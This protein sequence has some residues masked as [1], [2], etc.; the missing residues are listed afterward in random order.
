M[1]LSKQPLSRTEIYNSVETSVNSDGEHSKSLADEEGDYAEASE[2][3]SRSLEIRNG[4]KKAILMDVE[5]IEMV[6]LA[7]VV[8]MLYVLLLL[9]LSSSFSNYKLY[10]F[11]LLNSGDTVLYG[12]CSNVL[13][14]YNMFCLCH[15]AQVVGWLLV[16]SF[17]KNT[18]ATNLAKKS[19]DDRKSVSGSFML[20]S[21][22][23]VL[24][25]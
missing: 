14:A 24:H 18:I 22:W 3:Y 2:L 1:L 8:F 17:H 23:M 16:R 13:L 25:T 7:V 20:S 15:R 19:D 11:S 10:V 12:T 5:V 9:A 21:A 6:L 4:P